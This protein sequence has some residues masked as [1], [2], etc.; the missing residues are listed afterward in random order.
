MTFEEASDMYAMYSISPQLTCQC[1]DI[2]MCQQCF[3]EEAHERNVSAHE[4]FDYGGV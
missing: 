3:E 4:D 1:D 2:H